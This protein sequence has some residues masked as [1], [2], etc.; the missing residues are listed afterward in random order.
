MFGLNITKRLHIKP[1]A[2]TKATPATAALNG[3]G[4]TAE[5]RTP[6]ALL[7]TA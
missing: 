6:Q 2:R 1:I 5:K 3:N 4:D 7:L